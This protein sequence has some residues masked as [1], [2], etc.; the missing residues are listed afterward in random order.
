MSPQ[1]CYFKFP[2]RLD[3]DPLLK[4]IREK[5]VE[6]KPSSL[7]NVYFSRIPKMYS[8][9]LNKIFNLP[10][11]EFFNNKSVLQGV[12]SIHNIIPFDPLDPVKVP[13]LG[14]WHR[15]HYRDSVIIITIS[16]DNSNHYT[17]YK[18]DSG[19]VFK[20]PYEKGIPILLN[21]KIHHKV[22]NCCDTESRNAVV[23][24]INNLEFHNV[25]ELYKQNKLVKQKEL[26]NS[27]LKKVI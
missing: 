6:F 13:A 20:V 24:S 4:D 2:F 8:T 5:K 11:K 12:Y 14:K 3:F 21:T 23:I 9:E 17:E 16:D 7:H 19:E 26:E 18:L 15:D 25:L 22:T 1:D 27:F 10:D